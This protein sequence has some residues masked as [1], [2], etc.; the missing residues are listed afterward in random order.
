MILNKSSCSAVSLPPGIMY[1]FLLTLG[2]LSTGNAGMG[3][4][5]PN[6]LPYHLHHILHLIWMR[7]VC[8]CLSS[9]SNTSL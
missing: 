8:I 5:S 7:Y 4:R 9:T 1:L 3:P 2:S 6:M